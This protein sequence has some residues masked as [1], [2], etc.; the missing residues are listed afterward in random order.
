MGELHKIYRR[1]TRDAMLYAFVEG[2][3]CRD[4]AVSVE[5]CVQAFCERYGV[6]NLDNQTGKAMYYKMLHEFRNECETFKEQIN[7]V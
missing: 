4:Q 2:M 6:E 5:M 7:V 3:R 1:Q